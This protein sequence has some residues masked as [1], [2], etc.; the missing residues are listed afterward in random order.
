MRVCGMST[1][2][3]DDSGRPPIVPLNLG[4]HH[5]AWVEDAGLTLHTIL[6]HGLIPI[7]CLTILQQTACVSHPQ[8]PP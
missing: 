5:Q 1:P 3:A 6:C 2:A 4:P 8:P 7:L